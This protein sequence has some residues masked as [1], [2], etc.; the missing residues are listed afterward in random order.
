LVRDEQGATE[1]TAD[2]A[3]GVIDAQQALAG[4]RRSKVGARTE[5]SVPAPLKRWSLGG[6]NSWP[7]E[8]GRSEVVVLVREVL[9]VTAVH[10][11]SCGGR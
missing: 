10:L 3:S 6:Q 11:A 9:W 4:G 1:A 8:R 7:S 2:T 5:E